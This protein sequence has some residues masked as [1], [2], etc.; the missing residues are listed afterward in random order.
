MPVAPPTAAFLKK[1]FQAN[2]SVQLGMMYGKINSLVRTFFQ[3]RSL[4]VTSQAKP[5][6]IKIA[7]MQALIE[8]TRLWA[9][10]SYNKDL[11]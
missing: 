10:G 4:R 1:F 6:P 8:Q 7:T 2:A 11:L 5:P 3:R 9:S